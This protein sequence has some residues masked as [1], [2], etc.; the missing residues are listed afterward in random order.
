VDE[1]G[2]SAL[3]WCAKRGY[4]KLFLA[5]QKDPTVSSYQIDMVRNILQLNLE[6]KFILGLVWEKAV[7]SS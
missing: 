5:L 1:C 3:H 7:R 2:L 6:N 4:F